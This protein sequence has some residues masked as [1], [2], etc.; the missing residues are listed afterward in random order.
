MAWRVA[1]CL[2]QLLKQV[3]AAAPHRS[4]ASD[5]SIGDADHATRESDHNPWVGPV[6]GL[7]IVTARDFTHDPAGG[8]D[9]YKFAEQLKAAKD[10]RVKYVISNRRIWSLARNSEG[11]RP[12]NGTN[13]HNKHTHVSCSSD[14][15]LFDS[16]T[17]WKIGT[18]TTGDGMSADDVKAINTRIAT[19]ETSL[20]QGID[21]VAARLETAVRDSIEASGRRWALYEILYGLETE[22][23]REAAREAYQE[24]KTKGGTDAEAMAAAEQKLSGLRAD[25][26][27]A[28]AGK[29]G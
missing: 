13:P 3:N 6:G 10:P 28:Q 29:A 11:W 17:S 8:F 2:D 5:G 9:A 19:L 21:G 1:R 15:R 25:I 27:A 16:V 14:E 7:M 4:K 24:V 26:K 20:K 18:T 22:D 23:D 12:Y